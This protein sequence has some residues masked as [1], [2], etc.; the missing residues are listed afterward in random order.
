MRADPAAVVAALCD[1]AAAL[2]ADQPVGPA[3]VRCVVADLEAALDGELDP[4]QAKALA[5]AVE[6]LTE[7]AARRRDAIGERLR[8]ARRGRRALHGY[9]RGAGR[10]GGLRRSRRA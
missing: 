8:R 1:L 7:A 5:E 9:A 10:R 3:E 4:R 2:R 6:A